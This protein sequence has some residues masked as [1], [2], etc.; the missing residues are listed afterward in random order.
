MFYK[1]YKDE[2]ALLKTSILTEITKSELFLFNQSHYKDEKTIS[3][4]AHF[5]YLMEL[6]KKEQSFW[7][8][9]MDFF[10]SAVAVLDKDQNIIHFNPSLED[11]LA[12][13]NSILDNKPNLS[14]LVS[15]PGKR[16]SLCEFI[17]KHTHD[18]QQSGF[19]AGDIIYISTK[20]ER[21][22]PIFVFVIPVFDE[23]RNLLHSFIIMRDRRTEF[24]LRK[25]YMLHQSSPIIS[26]LQTISDGDIS[27]TLN[28]PEEN[29]LE[30]Y[31]EPINQI[32]NSFQDIV[33]QIQNA[34][35]ISE[36]STQETIHQLNGLHQWGQDKF[37]P[38]LSQVSEEANILASSI[39]EISNIVE[40]IK[41]ISDQTNLLALNAAIEAARAGEHGRGFAVV[42]DEV[43]K[44]AEKSQHS[45]NDIENIIS[46]IQGDSQNMVG[47]V[48]GFMQES[49]TV[50]NISD[51][52]E[53]RFNIIVEQLK[54]LHQSVQKFKI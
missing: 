18:E 43:R 45:T 34:L 49:E 24:K 25:E 2:V 8:G 31:K 50:M 19:S 27:S 52:L 54:I 15:E 37:I 22:I 14:S 53:Q 46:Q 23:K 16:C 4:Q 6:K 51:I 21:N 9:F 38:T 12:V 7:S 1:K 17:K 48:Q 39:S 44:L 13:N 20:K 33:L 29:E 11:F 5:N 35:S 30:H 28:L 32:I 42:A 26:M 36:T 3:T 41:D 40:L 10:P 47:N